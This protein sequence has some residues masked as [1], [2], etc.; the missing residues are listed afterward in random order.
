MEDHFFVHF[1]A[2]NQAGEKINKFLYFP[3]NEIKEAEAYIQD[4]LTKE[5][6]LNC[7]SE[8]AENGAQKEGTFVCPA[9]TV[10]ADLEK[11]NEQHVE[12]IDFLVEP[13]YD[14]T[15]A[16]QFK[17][18]TMR[19]YNLDIT[20]TP[21]SDEMSAILTGVKESFDPRYSTSVNMD[22]VIRFVNQLLTQGGLSKF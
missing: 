17:N 12:G 4:W 8:G 15:T 16:R 1:K 5:C 2:M 3:E 9:V 18:T 20:F 10:P 22:N 21:M 13:I 6:K 14:V 19:E 11:Y 7:T